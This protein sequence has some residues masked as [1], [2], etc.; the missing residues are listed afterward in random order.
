MQ[1]LPV[2][3]LSEPTHRGC[4]VVY[5]LRK[6]TVVLKD[7]STHSC[8]CYVPHR[9]DIGL[10]LLHGAFRQSIP[11]TLLLADLLLNYFQR[12]H[13]YC[14][15]HARCPYVAQDRKLDVTPHNDRGATSRRERLRR[16]VAAPLAVAFCWAKVTEGP[17]V[18]AGPHKTG[19]YTPNSVWWILSQDFPTFSIHTLSCTTPEVPVVHSHSRDPTFST[20]LAC[21]T[22]TVPASLPFVPC[23]LVL[24]NFGPCRWG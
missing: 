5:Q 21:N 3:P 23:L 4:G 10:Q 16:S 12:H 2:K 15:H 18:R 9:P 20:V 13:S 11:W 19:E 7:L 1:S 24:L 17:S 8:S 6:Q 22:Y 14:G